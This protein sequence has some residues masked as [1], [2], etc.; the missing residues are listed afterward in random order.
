MHRIILT[1]CHLL[2]FGFQLVEVILCTAIHCHL[3]CLVKTPHTNMTLTTEVALEAAVKQRKEIKW[4][5]TLH[6]SRHLYQNPEGLTGHAGLPHQPAHTLLRPR[7][8]LMPTGGEKGAHFA[9][10]WD[11]PS[12]L[13]CPCKKAPQHPY[14][15]RLISHKTGNKASTG[16][17][18]RC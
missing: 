18:T 15:L 13:H 7:P 6:P 14:N 4:T 17:H 11:T 9:R 12:P 16:V 5:I 2:V 1:C 10:V 8:G 3:T